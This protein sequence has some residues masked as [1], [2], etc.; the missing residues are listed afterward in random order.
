MPAAGLLIYGLGPLG[1]A[2]ALKLTPSHQYLA[3]HLLTASFTRVHARLVTRG[4][5]PPLWN[6]PSFG[7]IP[8]A[9]PRKIF[10]SQDSFAAQL[11][12]SFDLSGGSK[13][14]ACLGRRLPPW[15]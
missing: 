11:L 15:G 14:E 5:K 8:G 3:T 10:P 1:G 9:S 6:T 13:G 4:G 12:T 7:Q 2:Y